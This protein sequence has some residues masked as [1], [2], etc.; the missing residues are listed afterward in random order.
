MDFGKYFVSALAVRS[1]HYVKKPFCMALIQV[2]GSGLNAATCK[3]C[4]FSAF[5]VVL[6]VLWLS[7][8]VC[9]PVLY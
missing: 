9:G 1:G 4:M 6:Y 8:G 7:G 2:A 5:V 3:Y